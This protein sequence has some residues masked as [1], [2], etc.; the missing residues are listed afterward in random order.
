MVHCSAG[1]GRSGTI[2]AIDSAIGSLDNCGSVDVVDIIAG[3][4]KDRVMLVQHPGQCEL[5]WEACRQYAASHAPKIGEGVAWKIS[6]EA[7][8]YAGAGE[9]YLPSE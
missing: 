3:M 7:S 4:R 5:V 8:K 6:T 2:I 9:R 1:V